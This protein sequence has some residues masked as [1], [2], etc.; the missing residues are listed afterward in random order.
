MVVIDGGEGVGVAAEPPKY[1]EIRGDAFSG[2]HGET[3]RTV[4]LSG[5]AVNEIIYVQGA[6][7]HSPDYS[8]TT[9]ASVSR[10]T[11]NNKIYD[12]FYVSVYYWE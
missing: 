1:I 10:L 5:V 12:Q 8:K 7:V 4:D 9:V 2:S 6:F 11:F 3:S